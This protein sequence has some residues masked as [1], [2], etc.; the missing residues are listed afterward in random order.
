MGAEAGGRR[1][2]VSAFLMPLVYVLWF[3]PM[4]ALG[5]WLASLVGAY[6][7]TMT[8]PDLVEMGVG[9]WLLA[10]LYGL[11]AGWPSWLGAALAV[12]A[13]RRGASDWA[14]LALGLNLGISAVLLVGS[15][16]PSA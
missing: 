12:V 14:F 9:G 4:L 2:L 16:L 13:R 15:V 8:S 6:P 5:W 10:L 7:T 1:Y 3:V 11:V